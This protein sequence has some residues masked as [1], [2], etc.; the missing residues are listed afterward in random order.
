MSRLLDL[1]LS[2][3]DTVSLLSLSSSEGKE[4]ILDLEE[5]KCALN[6]LYVWHQNMRFKRLISNMRSLILV[7]SQINII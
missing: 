5:K 6:N 2:L 7:D 1:S 3:V 4:F